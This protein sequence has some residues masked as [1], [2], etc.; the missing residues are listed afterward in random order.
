MLEVGL[1][2][3]CRWHPGIAH[4]HGSDD[5]AS[6]LVLYLHRGRRQLDGPVIIEVVVAEALGQEQGIAGLYIDAV[7]RGG[8]GDQVV[9]VDDTQIGDQGVAELLPEFGINPV[10][11]FPDDDR[12]VV[13]RP[14]LLFQVLEDELRRVHG[15]RGGH[16]DPVAL[17]PLAVLDLVDV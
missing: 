3:K 17:A 10:Q 1:P 5:L 7:N 16:L 9:A 14:T 12:P 11:S 6:F 2:E 13:S 4:P 8:C 15:F